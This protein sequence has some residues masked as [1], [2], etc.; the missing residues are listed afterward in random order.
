MKYR[1]VL[2]GVV[3]SRVVEAETAPAL[4]RNKGFYARETDDPPSF[5]P[6]T[7]TRSG[8]VWT[9]TP[10]VSEGDIVTVEGTVEAAYAV[11]ARPANTIKAEKKSALK[12]KL[13]AADPRLTQAVAEMVTGNLSDEMKAWAKERIKL[14]QE[15]AALDE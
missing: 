1:L 10:P 12:A 4:H 5:D 6:A 3:Q 9:I 13:A 14:C 11:S 7:E 8:P 15:L 2:G